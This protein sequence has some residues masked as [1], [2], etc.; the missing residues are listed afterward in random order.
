MPINQNLL[1][2]TPSN[3]STT[4]VRLEIALPGTPATIPGTWRTICIDGDLNVDDSYETSNEGNGTETA[5]CK[6]TTTGLVGVTNGLRNISFTINTYMS[7]SDTGYQNMKTQFENDGAI[8]TRITYTDGQ[9][10]PVT[11]TL[12]TRG[13]LTAFPRNATTGQAVKTPIA[14]TAT[15][16]RPSGGW[17]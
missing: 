4:T 3:D 2:M 12:E 11:E 7:P 6:N 17:A 8:Y 5:W 14:F 13:K 10:S 15:A 16:I 1:V 9:G